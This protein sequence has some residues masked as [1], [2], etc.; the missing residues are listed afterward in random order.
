M[1]CRTALWGCSGT[2]L[3]LSYLKDVNCVVDDRWPC[4]RFSKKIAMELYWRFMLRKPFQRVCFSDAKL[5]FFDPNTDIVYLGDIFRR[6]KVLPLIEKYG[7]KYDSNLFEAFCLSPSLCAKRRKDVSA[8]EIYHK[9]YES[10]NLKLSIMA[11]LIPEDVG[12]ICDVGCGNRTLMKFL[13][14]TVMYQGLDYKVKAD[15]II[16]IDLNKDEMPLLKVDCFFCCGILEFL[17]DV[18]AFLKQCISCNPK[19]LLLSYNPR[20]FSNIST[21]R[22]RVYHN[23]LYSHEIASIVCSKGYILSKFERYE[24]RQAFYLFK[25]L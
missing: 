25:R 23:C 19:Y 4:Y 17:D 15:N 5:Q 22:S 11:G 21:I 10:D 2:S 6:E 20:E 1:I 3:Q 14:H 12:S 8:K 16:N 24:S 18:E 13:P 7:F 9:D